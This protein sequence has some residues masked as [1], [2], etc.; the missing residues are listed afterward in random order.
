MSR[1]PLII[2]AVSKAFT[3]DTDGGEELRMKYRYLDL[4][5]KP[6]RDNLLLR[7]K[8]N[9]EVRKYLTDL[10]FVDI[11]TP[12]LIKSTP[13]G[14]RDF[15]VPSRM[16]E[17]EFYALPQ[18]PQTSKQL[19]MIGGMSFFDALCHSFTTMATGGYSTKQ[20]SIGHFQSPF[21]QYVIVVFIFLDGGGSSG[22]RVSIS[23]P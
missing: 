16:N 14:A 9:L 7:S 18:S 4:R 23:W 10:G 5:R 15:V 2:P 20:A 22:V 6:V 21:I 1:P 12:F 17:G 11:E 19:L 13:E 8:V 3:K